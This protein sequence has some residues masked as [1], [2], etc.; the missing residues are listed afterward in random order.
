MFYRQP[1]LHITQSLTRQA[2]AHLLLLNPRCQG[3]FYD[4]TS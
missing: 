1:F 2:T 4:P 3:L